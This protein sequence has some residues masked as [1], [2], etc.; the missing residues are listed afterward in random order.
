[1]GSSFGWIKKYYENLLL[2]SSR[3]PFILHSAVRLNRFLGENI[4]ALLILMSFELVSSSA[5]FP[6][7]FV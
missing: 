2:V 7:L 1:M 3:F 4:L 6:K 5:D